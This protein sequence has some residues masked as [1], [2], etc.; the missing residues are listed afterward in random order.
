MSKATFATDVFAAAYPSIHRKNEQ[1]NFPSNKY[2]VTGYLTEAENPQGLMQVAEAIKK[3]A[4]AKSGDLPLEQL[5]STGMKQEDDGRIK[6]KFTSNYKPKLSNAGGKALDGET[7]INPGDRIKVAGRAEAWD[8]GGRKG[9]SL[10]FSDVRLVEAVERVDPFGG[11][12][13]GF[14]EQTADEPAISF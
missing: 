4:S 6:V 1:G 5:A 11:P 13:D 3:A 14:E 9:V 7:I 8:A 2:E 12:E 10:Y